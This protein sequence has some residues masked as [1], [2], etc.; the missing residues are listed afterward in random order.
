MIDADIILNI[1]QVHISDAEA[2]NTVF[3]LR[4]NDLRNHVLQHIVAHLVIKIVVRRL[5]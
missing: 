1:L 5:I 2:E 4:V 3:V